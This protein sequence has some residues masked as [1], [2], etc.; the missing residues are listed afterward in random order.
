MASPMNSPVE[1]HD[2]IVYS[3]DGGGVGVVSGGSA[4]IGAQADTD[5]LEVRAIGSGGQLLVDV[6][7]A[8]VWLFSD[9]SEQ[10]LDVSDADGRYDCVGPIDALV[11]AGAGEEFVNQSPGELAARTVEALDI[12]YR[13][14]ASGV[15]ESRAD[16]E[17][18]RP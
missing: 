17:S 3:Y 1:L 9:G 15:L 2:A 12:A 10:R 16:I 11:A 13:S 14:A 18:L 8:A 7:R 5:A 6:E 4:H